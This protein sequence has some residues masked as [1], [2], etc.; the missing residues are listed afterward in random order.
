MEYKLK[1]SPQ[2]VLKLIKESVSLAKTFVDDVE[3]SAEDATR[4]EHDF[5]YKAIE[6]AIDSGAKTINIPD[7]VGYTTPTEYGN[8]IKK[9][10]DNVPNI[11]KAIYLCIAIMI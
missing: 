2:E 3:W 11:N 4:T 5:L 1:K 9:I 10:K 6:I 8:L 7:T